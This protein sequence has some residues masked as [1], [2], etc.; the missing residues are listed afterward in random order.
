[1]A[2]HLA[3]KSN[4]QE[5]LGRDANGGAQTRDKGVPADLRA[6]S[7]TTKILGD[8]LSSSG[9][10]SAIL[11]AGVAS[12]RVAVFPKGISCHQNKTCTPDDCSSPVCFTVLGFSQTLQKNPQSKL[13]FDQ[14]KSEMASTQPKYR[15]LVPD[16]ELTALQ[17]TRSM[18]KGDFNL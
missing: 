11:A 7:L 12:S 4:L 5:P 18:R 1:M 2:S 16:L 14:W 17:F 10:A 6:E 15:S 8:W 9:W 13:T 3:L